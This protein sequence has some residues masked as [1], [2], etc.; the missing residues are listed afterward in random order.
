MTYPIRKSV[1]VPLSPDAAFELFTTR[2]DVWWPL[3][4]HGVGADNGA[5]S[6]EIRVD[7]EAGGTVREI[8]PSGE[9]APWGTI[10]EYEPGATFRMTWHPGKPAEDATEIVV[11]F[12]GVGNGC[13][14]ELT[15]GRW[16]ARADAADAVN[17]YAQGWD[18]LLGVR[19]AGAARPVTA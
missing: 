17:S 5:P 11:T 14:V 9:E 15:H 18:F 8:L 4:S 13:R 1:D 3:E 7:T 6:K 2:M 10:L 19:F 16:E 12:M